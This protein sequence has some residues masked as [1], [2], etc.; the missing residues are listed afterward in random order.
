MPHR[1]RWGVIHH[2]KTESMRFSPDRPCDVATITRKE[3][4]EIK[5]AIQG[6][7]S[8]IGYNMDRNN[9]FESLLENGFAIP[10]KDDDDDAYVTSL[11]H[12]GEKYVAWYN[13]TGSVF[14]DKIRG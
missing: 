7:A 12:N 10:L 8:Y 5:K 14:L 13:S 1:L 2:T 11:E 3:T 9:W 6:E 4:D